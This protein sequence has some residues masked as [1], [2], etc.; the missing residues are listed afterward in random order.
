VAV[1]E[2]TSL[3]QLYE[4]IRQIL[5]KDFSHLED[6]KP[7]YRD[8]R[9]GDVRHSLADISKARELLGYEPSHSIGEGL[10]EA[11]SWYIDD[12]KADTTSG[13]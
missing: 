5:S 2:R 7:I 6:V 1:G 12:L 10:E 4:M 13:D 8:F 3:N 11:M 9:P